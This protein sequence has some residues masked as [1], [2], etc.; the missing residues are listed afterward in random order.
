MKRLLGGSIFAIALVLALGP[1]ALG[2]AAKAGYQ[3]LLVALLE[4]SPDREIL[5]NS[6]HQG[7]FASSAALEVLIPADPAS[8]PPAAPT[9]IRLDSRIQQGPGIWFTPRFPP[10]LGRVQTRAEIQGLPVALPALMVQTDLQ[11]DGSA[12]MRLQAPAG[13]TGVTAEALGLRHGELSGEVRLASDREAIS[14]RLVLTDLAVLA[15]TGPIARLS[16][17]GLEADL[18]SAG[19][20]T[21]RL[22][23]ARIEIDGMA[24]A[25]GSP[26]I[27]KPGIRLEGFGI[28]MARDTRDGQLDARLSFSAT[29][30][31]TPRETFG[32]SEIGLAAERLDTEALG[33][34]AEGMRLLGS[35]EVSQE[36]RGLVMAGLMARLLPR[37]AANGARLAVDPVRIQTPDGP[38]MGRLDLRLDPNAPLPRWPNLAVGDWLALFQVDGDLSEPE[39]IAL[40]WLEPFGAEHS[41]SLSDP[42]AIAA[43]RE[44]A[45]ALLMAWTQGGWISR[46]D[47]RVASAVRLG[48]GLLTVNGKTLPIR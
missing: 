25:G 6:Y 17:L 5:Q 38:A 33:D 3:D 36:M 45:G 48:D 31:S 12:S 2:H 40:S 19:A 39:A 18:P 16:E 14:G 4:R 9:R 1:L 44:E 34:L 26:P 35:G 15:T 8:R 29:E 30:L 21:G 10:L 27:G 41:L 23:V 28:R 11:V 7:W 22:D 46:Q 42:K 24:S 43:A 20:G 37:L 32:P 47:G 13:E